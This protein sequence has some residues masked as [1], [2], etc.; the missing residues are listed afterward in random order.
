MAA[1]LDHLIH[2]LQGMQDQTL[3][4]EPLDKGVV[5]DKVR[6][7]IFCLCLTKELQGPLDITVSTQSID[8]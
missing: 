2:D 7:Q 6:L 8:Q 1:I 3:T 4:T 5:D